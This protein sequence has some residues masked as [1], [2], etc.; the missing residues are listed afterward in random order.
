MPQ[1]EL[2][3]ISD[4]ILWLAK[5][6][7]DGELFPEWGYQVVLNYLFPPR[8]DLGLEGQLG[9]RDEAEDETPAFV[10]HTSEK[11]FGQRGD[12]ARGGQRGGGVYFWERRCAPRV[13]SIQS[14]MGYGV[15]GKGV[16][17][18]GC[19]IQESEG[20]QDKRKARREKPRCVF[21]RKKGPCLL[22]W[23]SVIMRGMSRQ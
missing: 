12:L 18:F 7:L 5:I 21:M 11:L 17:G 14:A 22:R 4:Q 3:I 20:E 15:H 16:D 6:A 19:A 23:R 1:H 2:M 9:R 8:A 10:G 13:V